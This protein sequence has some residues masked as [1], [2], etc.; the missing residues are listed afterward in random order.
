MMI[1]TLQRTETNLI[2]RPATVGDLPAC[3]AI[4]NDYIDATAWLPRVKSREE[5][6]GFFTPE[7]LE[8]RTVLVAEAHGQVVAYVSAADGFLF[9]IY[10]A[11][12]ARGGGI[13][14]MLL[15]G[16]KA[17]Y[18]EQIELTVYELN[19]AAQ[20]F[21]RREGFAEVAGEREDTEEGIP[22]MRMR[23]RGAA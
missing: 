8:K 3:A 5:I 18:P 14:K 23:W 10:L 6:A 9:A 17:R 2:I 4:I 13:G 11:P 12:A 21:Y 1:E 20:R 19:V 22:V 7:L 15:D 16:L